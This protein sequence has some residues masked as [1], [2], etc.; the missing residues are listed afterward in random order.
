MTAGTITGLELQKRNKE[1]VNVFLD[2]EYAFSLSLIQAAA[3]RKGQVL[4]AADIAALQEEDAVNS[5]VDRAARFLSYRPRST[6]EIHQH[7]ADKDMSEAV[8]EAALRRLERMGYLDDHA[9]ARYWVENRDTFKP[10]SPRALRYE[11]R[12]K[13]LTDSVI[14][15]VLDEF[16]VEDAARRAAQ[17]KVRRYRGAT[18]TEFRS[19]I[20]AFL[21]RRGFSY[22]I[23]RDVVE[24]LVIELKNEDF[25][26]TDTLENDE[27]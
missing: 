4:A 21:Q 2:D 7:L 27:F 20:G 26:D 11:L 24:Q 15:E 22:D 14:D 17:S 8:I 1:R 3:L 23:V 19:K 13:G 5:A 9:F 16:D 18:P 12:Q 10:R 6:Q 25:F